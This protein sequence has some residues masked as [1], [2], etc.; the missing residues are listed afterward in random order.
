MSKYDQIGAV[1]IPGITPDIGVTDLNPTK[2]LLV[3]PL[4]DEDDDD[5]PQEPTIVPDQHTGSLK[6]IFDY[7]KPSIEEE[8]D[9]GDE[10]DPTIE[11]QVEFNKL[12]DFQPDKIVE[13][14]P[15]LKRLNLQEDT[16]EALLT[17]IQKNKK[18]MTALGEKDLREAF[19][20]VLQSIIDELEAADA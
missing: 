11:V 20:D 19:I 6:K 15:L 8:L 18:L 2:M 5:A 4:R 14:I 10:E 13:Q 12:T 3:T 7:A 17:A 9:T 16:T 1:S